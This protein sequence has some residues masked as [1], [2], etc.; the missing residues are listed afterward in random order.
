MIKLIVSDL[1]GT[2]LNDSHDLDQESANAIKKAQEAG[3]EFMVATGRHDESVFPMFEKHGV[4]CNCI[5]LNGALYMNH[6]HEVL[7]EVVMD[8]NKA[9]KIMHLLEHHDIHAHLY[10]KEGIVAMHPEAIK[11]EF[12]NHMK[13]EGLSEEEISE[14]LASTNFMEYQEEITDLDAYFAK[15]PTVY[16]IEAFCEEGT[17]LQKLRESLKAIDGIAISSSIGNNFEI[18]EE[19]AQKGIMLESLLPTLGYRKEE[20]VFFG[21]SSNDL[22]MME[23][24]PYAVAMENATKEI[25]EAANYHIGKFSDHAVAN[26]ILD[27]IKQQKQ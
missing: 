18:T 23:R 13:A 8:G 3:F 7:K 10:V 19:Q 2:L 12:M 11:Q 26:A 16:K 4:S 20:V 21:D 25:L 22:S 27:I 1:D 9:S 15:Q 6:K 14:L 24:F 17:N 5:L